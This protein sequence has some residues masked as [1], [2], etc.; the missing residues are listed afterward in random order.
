MLASLNKSQE[1]EALQQIRAELETNTAAVKTL[2]LSLKK[3]NT[4]E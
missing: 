1:E 3:S 4:G 2:V